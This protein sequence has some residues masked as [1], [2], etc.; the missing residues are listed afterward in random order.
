MR[1]RPALLAIVV[2]A[3][4]RTGNPAGSGDSAAAPS[5]D[6]IAAQ[7]TDAMAPPVDLCQA[8]V[9]DADC[10][11]GHCVQADG[12]WVCARSC[13]TG[14]ACPGGTSCGGGT[15][16]ENK[17]VMV[18]LVEAGAC[19]PP[20]PP[21]EPVTPTCSHAPPSKAACCTCSGASCQANGCYNGW[22]CKLDTC[23]CRPPSEAPPCAQELPAPATLA[24]LEL[25][26]LDFAIVGDTRPP[27]KDNTKAY[28]SAII[29]KIWQDVQEE[30]PPIPLAVTTGDYVFS[31]AN[32]IGRAHV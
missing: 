14:E 30:K 4:A 12:N 27:N 32:E 15:T 22:V 13:E 29:K 16:A 20:P 5:T 17:N 9:T 28:P 23:A 10:A 6:A 19:S 25:D 31:D 2:V 1:W 3:C 11:A 7:S 21:P 24:T 18:C 26:A 8:C